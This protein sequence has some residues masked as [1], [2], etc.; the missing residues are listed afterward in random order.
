M[1]KIILLDSGPLGIAANPTVSIETTGFNRWLHKL[2]ANGVTVGIPDIADYEVRR[3]LIRANMSRGLR[4]L[5]GLQLEFAYLPVTTAILRRAAKLWAQA[6]NM[7]KP[8]A[9]A[10]SLDPLQRHARHL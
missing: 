2:W 6:R 8:T 1:S 10:L 3:E 7:G 5:D 4:K 9:D